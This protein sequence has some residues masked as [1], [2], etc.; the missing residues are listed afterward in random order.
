MLMRIG[1]PVV[2]IGLTLLGCSTFKPVQRE[3]TIASAPVAC[4]G[5]PAATCL[6]VTEL[7]GDTWR[8]EFDEI[9]GFAYEPGY[10]YRVLVEEPP[11]SD[12]LGVMP[13]LSLVRVLSEEP[14]GDGTDSSPLARSYWRLQSVSG[15]AG[16]GSWS[17]SGITAGFYVAGGW[18]DG[19]AGCNSYLGALSVR[20]KKITVSDPA[21][22][23]EDCAGTMEDRQQTYLDALAK[24]ESY[25]VSD[26]HLELTLSNG[27]KMQFRADVDAAEETSASAEG[28]TSRLSQAR[29]QAPGLTR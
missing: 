28:P 1:I 11:L 4:T 19:F 22:T 13:Q 24:A 18:V 25:E 29:R 23:L 15:A 16:N 26:D 10:T 2:A 7:D 9:D 27:G 14:A 21:T 6:K 12:E 3:L 20:G 8:M 17:A 5:S